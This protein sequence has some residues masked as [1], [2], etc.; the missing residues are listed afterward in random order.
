M[1]RSHRQHSLLPASPWAYLAGLSAVVRMDK[2]G[3]Q[4][5]TMSSSYRTGSRS[6][7]PPLDTADSMIQKQRQEEGSQNTPNAWGPSTGSGFNDMHTINAYQYFA[8]IVI[9]FIIGYSTAFL[10]KEKRELGAVS[11]IDSVT[12][13]NSLLSRKMTPAFP[14]VRAWSK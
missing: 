12:L 13:R 7:V 9:G 6:E 14:K 3:K 2:V 1:P 8:F 4:T 11:L 5:L 10:R